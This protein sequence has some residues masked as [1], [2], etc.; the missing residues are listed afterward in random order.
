[1]RDRVI[2][3]VLGAEGEEFG[4][5]DAENEALAPWFRRGWGDEGN[6]VCDEAHNGFGVVGYL[7]R[8]C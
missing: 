6:C 3:E 1:M 5:P 2:G 4:G 8:F 7:F